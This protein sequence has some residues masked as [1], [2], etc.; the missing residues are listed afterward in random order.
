MDKKKIK[1][2]ERL[3]AFMLFISGFLS[4]IGVTIAYNGS[5]GGGVILVIIGSLFTILCAVSNAKAE[6]Y[7]YG[8]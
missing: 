2:F 4:L 1:K 7:K 5:F 8:S 6:E 3:S